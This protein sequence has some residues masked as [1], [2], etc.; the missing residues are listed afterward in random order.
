VKNFFFVSALIATLLPAISSAGG[1]QAILGSSCDGTETFVFVPP[2]ADRQ[3]YLAD[4]VQTHKGPSDADLKRCNLTRD[5]WR[6]QV[7]KSN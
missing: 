5:Q 7:V 2:G 6:A 4:Y 3:K 1:T